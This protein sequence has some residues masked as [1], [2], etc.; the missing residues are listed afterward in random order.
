MNASEIPAVHVRGQETT[1]K[2][3]LVGCGGRG[4]GAT[5]EGHGHG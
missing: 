3:G 5:G 2:V 4:T 1:L